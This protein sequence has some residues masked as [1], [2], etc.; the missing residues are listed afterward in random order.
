M[1]IVASIPKRTEMDRK[2]NFG[3]QIFLFAWRGCAF[4][5]Y[6]RFSE[7]TVPKRGVAI[8]RL[9]PG[10]SSRFKMLNP[11]KSNYLPFYNFSHHFPKKCIFVGLQSSFCSFFTTFKTNK[12]ANSQTEPTKQ[13][14]TQK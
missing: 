6:C 10:S 12:S 1:Q 14:K 3:V 5:C 4:F 2:A 7:N 9:K 11:S 8:N 13:L